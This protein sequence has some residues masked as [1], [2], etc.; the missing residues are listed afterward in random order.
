M[1]KIT[2][3][4]LLIVLTTINI[5]SLVWIGYNVNPILSLVIIIGE[6][7]LVASLIKIESKQNNNNKDR[8]QF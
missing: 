4:T 6:T 3:V 1:N 2:I 8:I 7:W 5:A